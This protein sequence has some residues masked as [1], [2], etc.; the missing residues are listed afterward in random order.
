MQIARQRWNW[1]AIET[2]STNA[3]RVSSPLHPALQVVMGINLLAAS[4]VLPASASPGQKAAGSRGEQARAQGLV[5]ALAPGSS[6]GCSWAPAVMD[7]ADLFPGSLCSLQRG[8]EPPKSWRYQ[9]SLSQAIYCNDCA[10]P[11]TEVWLLSSPKHRDFMP[12]P[13]FCSGW[14]M[15]GCSGDASGR[16]MDL[17]SMGCVSNTELQHVR[18]MCPSPQPSP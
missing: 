15:V 9:P 4:R 1:N 5:S 10:Y 8:P 7:N 3:F 17:W 2:H 6:P 14:F 13:P 18:E 16:Y 12:C 11:G